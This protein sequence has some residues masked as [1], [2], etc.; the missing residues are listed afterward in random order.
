MNVEIINKPFRIN[1]YGFS[2]V[3]LNKDYAATAFKLSGRMW[4][5]VKSNNLKNGGINIWVYEP[6][7]LVFTGVVLDNIPGPGTGL[8]LKHL[9][10]TKY[11]YHKHVGAYRLLKQVGQKMQSELSSKGFETSLPYIEIYGHWTNDE[12]K[13]E[14]ELLMSLK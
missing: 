12:T 1:I 14:T 11:A 6:G 4:E 5:T 7:E 2:G 8:E 3:A 9:S 10:L 13:S